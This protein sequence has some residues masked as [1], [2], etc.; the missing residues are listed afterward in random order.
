MAELGLL[1]AK[2]QLDFEIAVTS[3][4]NKLSSLFGVNEGL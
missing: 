2:F 3:W 4:V 1:T